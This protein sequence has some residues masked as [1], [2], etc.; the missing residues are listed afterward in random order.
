MNQWIEFCD[1][2]IE[3]S[4]ASHLASPDVSSLLFNFQYVPEKP[5]IMSWLLDAEAEGA[6]RL[7]SDAR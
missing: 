7:F 5:D 6:I 4:K 1:K 2:Q 3:A